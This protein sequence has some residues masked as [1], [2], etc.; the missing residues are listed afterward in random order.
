MRSASN[1]GGK[2]MEVSG[3]HLNRG[4][5]GHKATEVLAILLQQ[6][7]LRPIPAR[8]RG[9]ERRDAA[10]LWPKT[11]CTVGPNADLQSANHCVLG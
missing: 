1:I 4:R 8:A 3:L 6:T 10:W 11:C 2:A 9:K 5:E 7:N